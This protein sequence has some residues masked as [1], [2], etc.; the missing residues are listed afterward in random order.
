MAMNRMRIAAAGVAAATALAACAPAGEPAPAM[1]MEARTA[2]GVVYTATSALLASYPVRI[3]ASA[4]A[5]NRSGRTVV[6]RFSDG[7]PVLARV[8]TRQGEPRWD[9]A[10]LQPCDG[11]PVEHTLGAGEAVTFETLLAAPQV[12][13]DSLPDDVYLLAV[14]LRPEGQRPLL[15]QAGRANLVV[16]R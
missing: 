1:E 10:A 5:T 3:R 4:T 11:P 9:Q 15:L 6:I 12:L 14:H 16:P 7:C 8:L 2:D 13:G